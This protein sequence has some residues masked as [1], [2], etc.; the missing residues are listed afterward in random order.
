MCMHRLKIVTG[1]HAETLHVRCMVKTLGTL[2]GDLS[3]W[4]WWI[5]QLSSGFGNHLE[6]DIMEMS[7]KACWAIVYLW[8][9]EVG[10]HSIV[11]QVLIHIDAVL[12]HVHCQFDVN[13]G[14]RKFGKIF[15]CFWFFVGLLSLWLCYGTL[16]SVVTCVQVSIYLSV[17]PIP[18]GR[19]KHEIVHRSSKDTLK[20]EGRKI[21]VLEFKRNITMTTI[22]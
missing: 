5:F 11:F 22:C 18:K 3:D 20:F 9:P 16:K 1:N 21:R 10:K 15:F 7:W 4:V 6:A 12:V 8:N 17:I 14:V 13:I 19:L 2:S